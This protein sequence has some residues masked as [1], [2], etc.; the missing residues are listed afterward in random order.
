[1]IL[2]VDMD[3]FY[4]SVEERDDPSLVG[5]PVIVGGT[6]EGRG[7]VA[8]ANYEARKFGVHSAMPSAHG[9]AALPARGR[10]SSR[11]WTTT[12]RSRGRSAKSSSS[13]RRWS[14][15]CRSTRRFSTSPAAS[16]LFGSVGRDR[17]AD[18]A[19][20]S[21]RAAARRLGRRGAEQV[22]R[23]DRQRSAEAGRLRR[24]RARSEC[25]S[26]SIR[27]RS[28][29]CGASARSP[30][31]SFEQ[32]G[33]RTIG[34]LRQLPLETLNDLFGSSGEHYWQLAHGI[35]DRRVVPDREA[36]SISHETTFAARHRR[37][38]GAAGLAGGTRRAGRAAACGGTS[39]RGAR[40][41]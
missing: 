7:V 36:K 3:A 9:R 11:G 18:Q 6:A 33:I 27:C 26:F 22:R 23:Q 17:P 31:K 39:S 13:S 10:S 2:H 30:A 37:P 8:A 19:A 29:G 5:K 15:R 32:L 14:S 1:M 34:Q 40:S 16:R 41:N 12:P 38:G 35:D 25:R 4:A 28:D 21:R 24:R 20:D